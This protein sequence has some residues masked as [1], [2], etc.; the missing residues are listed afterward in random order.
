MTTTKAMIVAMMIILMM[1]VIK[2]IAISA[3]IIINYKFIKIKMIMTIPP[4]T[5][6]HQDDDDD[7]DNVD[8]NT[9]NNYSNN[10]S[11]N[12]NNNIIEL[13]ALIE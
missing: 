8:I 6:N 4:I 5:K 12:I 10:W 3:I 13:T 2:G 1:T 11:Y 7:A 9:Y